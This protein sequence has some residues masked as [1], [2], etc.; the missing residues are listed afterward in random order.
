[1]NRIGQEINL[2]QLEKSNA[3]SIG[4]R[5]YRAGSLELMPKGTHNI[6]DHNY[7]GILR[8]ARI[9]IEH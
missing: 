8:T 9:T 1:M 5:L 4:R 6:W 2:L 3:M 7:T